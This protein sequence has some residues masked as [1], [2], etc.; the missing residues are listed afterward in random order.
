M[1]SSFTITCSIV[2]KAKLF[3]NI[4][5]QTYFGE[6]CNSRE[7]LLFNSYESIFEF[8]N[9]YLFQI[10]NFISLLPT[11]T[12]KID[13]PRGQIHNQTGTVVRRCSSKWAFLK[14]SKTSQENTCVGASFYKVGKIKRF[15]HKCFPVKIPNFLKNFSYRTPLVAAS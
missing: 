10:T 2:Y 12:Q 11:F 1:R 5:W 15:R 6:T 9:P 8:I 13:F 4:K 14:I 7:K 3:E